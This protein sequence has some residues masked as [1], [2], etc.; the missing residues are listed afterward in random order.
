MTKS[1]YVQ[2]VLAA[3]V[4][5]GGAAVPLLVTP[6]TPTAWLLLAI[7]EAAALQKV[8]SVQSEVAGDK[9]AS[10]PNAAA[11]AAAVKVVR[12]DAADDRDHRLVR[13]HQ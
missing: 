10:Q 7:A 12:L 4:A 11:K 5:C 1:H 6:M 3:V 9:P 2:L 8:L 13:V